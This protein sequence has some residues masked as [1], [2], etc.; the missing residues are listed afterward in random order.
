MGERVGWMNEGDGWMK[1][2][3]NGWVKGMGGWRG[4]VNEGVR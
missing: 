2:E 1:G 4:W 3:E